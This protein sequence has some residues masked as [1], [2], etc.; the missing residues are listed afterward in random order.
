MSQP[1]APDAL[2]NPFYL[3]I[4]FQEI[5]LQPDI[6]ADQ[7]PSGPDPDPAGKRL[8]RVSHRRGLG[9]EGGTP[10]TMGLAQEL[11]QGC[12][13]A[14]LWG[15]GR[16]CPQTG[17]VPVTLHNGH[18]PRQSS[19]SDPEISPGGKTQEAVGCFFLSSCL[20]L[21]KACG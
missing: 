13:L 15:Q 3:S 4:T 20:L 1:P 18:P 17:K 11:G 19:S 21:P 2:Y 14:R 7:P 16:V 9:G 6:K 12:V 8:A 10:C 5:H